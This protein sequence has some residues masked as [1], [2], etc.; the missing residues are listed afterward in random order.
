MVVESGP[1]RGGEKLPPHDNEAEAAVV[2]SLLV[3]PE[4]IFKVA[5]RLKGNDFFREKNG[6]VYDACRALWDR[7]EA[8]NQITVAHELE[9]SARLEDVGGLAYLSRLVTD[10]PTSVGC[11]N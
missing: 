6:W 7:N 2:A 8:I 10:L 4:A 3:D 11:A 9:R 5:P 1:A